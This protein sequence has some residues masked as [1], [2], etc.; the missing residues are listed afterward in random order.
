MKKKYA[1][2]GKFVS[3]KMTGVQRFSVEILKALDKIV[4]QGD[5]ELVVPKNALQNLHF[6]NIQ[7]KTIGRHT[8][9]LWEQ[10]DYPIYLMREKREG[11]NLGNVAPVIKPDYVCVHD[12]LVMRYP[13]WYRKK[14]YFWMKFVYHCVFK[15]AK[16]IFTVSEFS[17]GEIEYFYPKYNG[18]IL[19]IS[20]G[21]QHITKTIKDEDC[22]LE[23][24]G[25]KK[26]TYYFSN[27]QL[28]PYKNFKWIVEMAKYNSLSQFVVTGWKNMRVHT[29]QEIDMPDNVRLLG[30]VSD[31][32]LSVLIKNC[33]AFLFPS[34]YEGFG[35]PP[36]EALAYGANVIVSDIPVFNEV[37]GE[38]VA[39][40][41]PYD[42]EIELKDIAYPNKDTR[43]RILN[44]YS[45]EKGAMILK[46]TILNAGN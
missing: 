4:E 18:E 6:D 37:L 22:V 42:Y 41:D 16:K 30:Y 20:E 31:E 8:G 34:L 9:I 44:N 11:I 28:A 36:I 25:L 32:D 5:F 46:N 12:M 23:K 43:D 1:V 39:H 35:L 45:W 19:V 15:N 7:V 40:I 24:Y 29:E 10:I 27:Y 17:K 26:N 33:K 2:N 38:A 21:W 13:D 3:Q 14:Y